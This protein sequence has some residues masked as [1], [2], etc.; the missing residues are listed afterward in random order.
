MGANA[1]YQSLLKFPSIKNLVLNHI[2]FI[3]SVPSGANVRIL[4]ESACDS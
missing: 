4:N 1:I 2:I 3:A